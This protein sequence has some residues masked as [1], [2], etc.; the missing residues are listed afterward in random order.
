VSGSRPPHAVPSIHPESIAAYQHRPPSS[1]L[2][3]P[4][5]RPA[6]TPANLIISS[7]REAKT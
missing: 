7:A 6:T 4:T 3:A 1:T 5:A 2:R